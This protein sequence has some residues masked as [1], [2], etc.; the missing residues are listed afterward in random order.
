MWILQQLNEQDFENSIEFLLLHGRSYIVGRKDCDI[1]LNGDATISRKHAVI[2]IKKR[3]DDEE[4]T[5]VDKSKV[6]V[7]VN[8]IKVQPNQ[9]INIKAND[10]IL[11]GK[12]S[13]NFM[14]KRTKINVVL[15]GISGSDS[16]KNCKSLIQQLGGKILNEWN[17]DTTHLIMEKLT[18]TIKVVCALASGKYIVTP[19]YFEDL[20][21]SCNKKQG[22]IPL[23]KS[24]LPPIAENSLLKMESFFAP[25]F[26][27]QSL[28]EGKQLVVLSSSQCMRIRLAF[29]LAGGNVILKT[30]HDTAITNSLSSMQTLVLQT[31]KKDDLSASNEENNWKEVVYRK[32][33]SHSLRPIRESEIG[34]AILYASLQSFCNPTNAKAPKISTS[35]SQLITDTFATQTLQEESQI[36]LESSECSNFSDNRKRKAAEPENKQDF[37]VIKKLKVLSTEFTSETFKPKVTNIVSLDEDD[38]SFSEASFEENSF[39]FKPNIKTEKTTSKT[40][41]DFGE[42]K[43]D[44]WGC[45]QIFDAC[46]NKNQIFDACVNKNAQI[47]ANKSKVASE[48]ITESIIPE[49]KLFQN[50]IFDESVINNNSVPVGDNFSFHN[51]SN[52]VQLKLTH[53]TSAHT[54]HVVNNKKEL[55][56]CSESHLQVTNVLNKEFVVPDTEQIINQ[57][58]EFGNADCNFSNVVESQLSYIKKVDLPK[59][60]GK[61]ELSVDNVKK[62]RSFNNSPQSAKSSEKNKDSANIWF[63]KTSLNEN[64]KSNYDISSRKQSEEKNSTDSQIN[65]QT[66]RLFYESVLIDDEPS[67]IKINN[68]SYTSCQNK[69]SSV[70]KEEDADPNLDHLMQ[71]SFVSLVVNSVKSKT[72][73]FPYPGSLKKPKNFKVFRKQRYIGCDKSARDIIG[74]NNL[75]VYINVNENQELF[76]DF[77]EEND[78]EEEAEKEMN[79][80]FDNWGNNKEP[81]R[82]TKRR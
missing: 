46:V 56:D 59:K 12:Y 52:K 11:F 62:G 58:D 3:L 19:K 26:K 44:F 81:A 27:R 38:A 65:L 61:K 79:R 21:E 47:N 41:N 33:K 76:D 39:N 57:N 16:K 14:L 23:E 30:K 7:Y 18:F 55:L 74:R 24:Y 31:E 68:K 63:G 53:V 42:S 71:I 72:V 17:L 73:D 82:K 9:E 36:L 54:L 67:M 10:V 28:M 64:S 8:K 22:K 70:K 69:K 50:S 43:N 15:S 78:R 51:M 80:L 75:T 40:K 35:H 34:L 29:E 49:S 66:E 13:V 25:D 60:L 77:R 20:F 5:I 1:V 37:P 4:V 32:L 45:S 6:G 48:L 2:E